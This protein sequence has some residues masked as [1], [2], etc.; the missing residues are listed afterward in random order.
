M[1][2]KE[3]VQHNARLIRAR[4]RGMLKSERGAFYARLRTGL[5]LWPVVVILSAFIDKEK[6]DG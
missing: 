6:D 4:V 5:L 2:D 3:R 1:T